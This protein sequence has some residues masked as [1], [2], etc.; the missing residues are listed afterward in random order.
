METLKNGE[1]IEQNQPVFE[2]AKNISEN[3][4]VDEIDPKELRKFFEERCGANFENLSEEGKEGLGW[5]KE[6]KREL[7]MEEIWGSKFEDYEEWI[8]KSENGYIVD[9]ETRKKNLPKSTNVPN[10]INEERQASGDKGKGERY[11]LGHMTAYVAG[12]LTFEKFKYLVESSAINGVLG[13]MTSEEKGDRKKIIIEWPREIDPKK[14]PLT[15]DPRPSRIH[16]GEFV[17][18]DKQE[19]RIH[20]FPP[21]FPIKALE[22]LMTKSST[23]DVKIG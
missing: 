8:V 19:F 17:A 7:G 15:K 2:W 14:G 5:Y 6:E 23:N 9:Y 12:S 20:S 3:Q 4:K 18:D 10:L 21:E 16:P 13:E 11:L 1:D 22:W